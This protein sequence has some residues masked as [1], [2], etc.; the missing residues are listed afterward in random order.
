[1]G[2]G[3][4]VRVIKRL[5]WR[6]SLLLLP[7]LPPLDFDRPAVDG[8]SVWSYPEHPALTSN[9]SC[10]DNGSRAVLLA[11]RLRPIA[12][13]KYPP[14]IVKL[15]M[16]WTHNTPFLCNLTVTCDAF[17]ENSA[18]AAFSSE[19]FICHIVTST[20][21]SREWTNPFIFDSNL[22]T[23]SRRTSS[24]CF[25]LLTSAFQPTTIVSP[26]SSPLIPLRIFGSRLSAI[27]EKL[28]LFSFSFFSS[29]PP[30][31]EEIPSIALAK[32]DLG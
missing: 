16:P 6:F 17:K 9:M 30:K 26:F 19:R 13:L 20:P 27:M 28:G 24:R 1:M 8:S 31:V 15:T 12:L 29:P 14:R 10:I 5:P 32:L 22:C 4:A 7:P 2:V 11:P 21:S 25:L 3:V 23:S 18:G